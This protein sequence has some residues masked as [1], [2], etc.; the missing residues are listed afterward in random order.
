MKKLTQKEEEMLFDYERKFGKQKADQWR[1]KLL[2]AAKEEVEIQIQETTIPDIT[3]MRSWSKILKTPDAKAYLKLFV[4]FIQMTNEVRD[5]PEWHGHTFMLI[6][7]PK[8]IVLIK[9]DE[10]VVNPESEEN[11]LKGED[12][13]PED[14]VIMGDTEEDEE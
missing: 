6:R 3:K 5:L 8:N 7:T 14:R 12:E 2:D 9:K 13:L 1:Q 10:I 11:I 4:K